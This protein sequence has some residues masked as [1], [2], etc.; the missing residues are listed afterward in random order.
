MRIVLIGPP[1][2]GKGTQANRLASKY[3]IPHLST[4]ELLRDACRQRT[5]VG[6]QAEHYMK[7]GKLVPDSLVEQVVDQRLREADAH[8]GF[9]MDGFPRTVPQAESF[10]RMLK[11]RRE[12]L[13]LV[14][15]FRVG[16]D[17]L[18]ER[19]E[20]RGRQDDAAEIVHQRFEQYQQHTTPLLDYYQHS[21]RLQTVDGHGSPDQ[22]YQRVLAAVQSAESS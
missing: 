2:A 12:P 14:L 1:G 9:V 13:D 19:L 5:E 6:R 7:T 8:A 3:S 21:G 15:E 10:D 22:V 17:D 18:L 20:G 11:Q 4:G 16:E